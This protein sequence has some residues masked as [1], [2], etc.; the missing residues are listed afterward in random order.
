MFRHPDMSAIIDLSRMPY[1]EKIGYVRSALPV[2]ASLRRSRGFPHAIAIDEAHYF[3]HDPEAARL[4]DLEL[5][6]YGLVT[7]RLSDVHPD[8]LKA[9]DVVIVNRTT[10]P[11][12][13]CAL[14][15]LSNAS[16]DWTEIFGSLNPGEAWLLP[17]GDSGGGHKIILLSRLT[18]H[19]RHRSKYLDVP[20]APGCGFLF[21][22]NGKP[23][24]PPCT[25][26]LEFVSALGSVPEAALAEHARRGDFSRWVGEVFRDFPLAS[27]IRKIEERCRTGHMVKPGDEIRDAIQAHYEVGSEMAW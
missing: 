8:L 3:L 2:L 17:S 25:T 11:D 14:Q 4:L 6:A 22:L 5:G 21:T 1:E 15:K 24:R 18:A 7:Y 13:V 9:M 26:L 20:V 23:L 12:E 19:V 16:A 10:D 27:D